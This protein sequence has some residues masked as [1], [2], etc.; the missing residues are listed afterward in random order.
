MATFAETISPADLLKTPF[1]NEPFIDFSKDSNARAM[2]SALAKVRSELGREYDLVIGGDLVRTEGKIKSVNPAKP[3]E[4]VGVHQKAGPEHV[5]PAMKA[6]LAAF[7][8]WRIAPIEER[9]GLLL[10]ASE[11]IKQR[12]FEFNAWLVFEVG[13]NWAEADADIAETIDFLE[14]Y[15]REAL[16]LATARPPIQ[17]PGERNQLLYIPLGVGAVIPP[18]N[19]PFAIMAGMTAASIVCG[20]TVVLKPSSDAPTIAARFLDVL[21]EAGMPPGVVNLS[22]A[23][24]AVGR[25]I[26]E[27]P[28]TRYIAF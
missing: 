7:E 28:R 18:W 24:P 13:K 17:Y 11:I 15:A 6:A 20:N 8:T 27:D 5:E 26:V 10:R 21:E 9:V 19:F 12:R 4:V 22:W 3:S 23:G 14:F 2:R 25:A 1:R 16:R